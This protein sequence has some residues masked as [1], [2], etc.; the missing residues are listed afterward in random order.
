MKPSRSA[1]SSGF[2]AVLAALLAAV[3]AFCATPADAGPLR[4]LAFGDSLTAGYGLKPEEAFPAVLALRLR[5]DGYDVAVANAGISGETTEMGL[6]RFPRT[7]GE[8]ADL[9][10]L[11]LGGNDMLNNV[12]PRVTQR[13]LEKIIRL[14]R[15]KNA[16]VL[17]AGMV[18]INQLRPAA[19]QRFDAIFSTLAVKY[20]LPLYP[21]FL[22]GVGANPKLTQQGGLHPTAE[23]VRRIVE[24]IAPLVEQTLGEMGAPRL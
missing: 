18:D 14:A 23:G 20:S 16:R 21:F 10:I 2:A 3:L 17:L 22:E 1:G 13:N 15:A 5:D 11:E 7:L 24:R 9:V 19:K 4:I 8:G 6:A 12:D